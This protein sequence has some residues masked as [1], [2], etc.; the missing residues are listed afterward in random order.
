MSDLYDEIVSLSKE[1]TFNEEAKAKAVLEK[2][3]EKEKK[4]QE[5]NT[6]WA[7]EYFL[8]TVAP[9]LKEEST[10]IRKRQLFTIDSS[11][12][13]FALVNE[14][15]RLGFT[16]SSWSELSSGPCGYKIYYCVSISWEI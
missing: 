16:S 12:K 7:K 13:A 14:A 1:A 2:M 9:A 11:G 15:R 4:I 5:Q 8:E 6:Q 10:L 3:K